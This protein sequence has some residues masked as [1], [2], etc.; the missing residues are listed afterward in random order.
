M[1]DINKWEKSF[2]TAANQNEVPPPA[3][4]WDKIA[5]E[6]DKKRKRRAIIWFFSGLIAV[7]LTA[8]IYLISTHKSNDSIVINSTAK[9]TQQEVKIASN[10]VENEVNTSD[11]LKQ[12]E[13]GIINN[14]SSETISQNSVPNSVNNSVL[15][16]FQ[17]SKER[18]VSK[19]LNGQRAAGN[20]KESQKKEIVPFPANNSS[21]ANTNAVTIETSVKNG[22]QWRDN[23]HITSNQLNF[24]EQIGFLAADGLTLSPFTLKPN[25]FA[26]GVECYSFNKKRIVPYLEVEGGLGYPVRHMTSNGE[27]SNLLNNRND[28]EKPWYSYNASLHGGLILRNNMFFSTGF[29]YTEVKEKFDLIKTGVTKIVIDVDLI[30]GLPTDTSIIIGT[31]INS[32]ENRYKTFNIPLAIGYQKKMRNWMISGEIG[33]SY[34]ITLKTSGKILY[35]DQNVHLL[36]DIDGLYKKSTG[37]SVNAAVALHYYLKDN[38]SI[39]F[40]PQY[41]R[42]LKDWTQPTA[43]IAARYDILNFNVGIRHTF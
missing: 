8:G 22:V 9:T 7:S 34:N 19:S 28:T 27:P 24:P 29:N 18:T 30:T 35:T 42:S 5:L 16:T 13:V 38:L 41:A 12:D 26:K 10:E 1:S 3:M 31:D 40:K 2:R 4:V 36:Q 15:N 14:S 33:A 21:S 20:K 11:A 37:L 43:S 39:Y 17:K 23:T 25:S 6:L 32:G